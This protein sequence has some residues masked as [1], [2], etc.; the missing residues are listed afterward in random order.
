MHILLVEDNPGDARMLRE[1]VAEEG[2]TLDTVTHADRLE[3]GL[4]HVAEPGID[5]V[6][7]DLSLP[8]STGLETLVRMHAAAKEVPIVVLTGVEDEALGV[9]LVQTGAQDYLVKGQVTA[10][11]LRRALRYAMERKARM[12]ELRVKQEQLQALAT[13]LSLAEQRER[14]RIAVELHDYLGQLL[15]LGRLKLGQVRQGVQDIEAMEHLKAADEFMSQALAYTRTLVAELSPPMLQEFGLPIALKWLAEQMQRYELRVEV[16]IELEPLLLSEAQAVLLFQSA[17]EL[18]INVVKH[19]R[20]SHASVFLATNSHGEVCL[21]VT[22]AGCGFDPAATS[23]GAQQPVKFGLLSIRERMEALGGRFELQSAP[24][25]GTRATLILSAV[26]VGGTP[27]VAHAAP[28]ATQLTPV[29]Q[30]AHAGPV[31]VLLV[32]DHT[33][34]RQGVR[35]LLD[36]EPCLQV[37]G[38]AGDGQEAVELARSLKPDVVL[39]DINMPKMDGIEATRRIKQEQ[40]D[41]IVI[42]LSVHNS[43]TM[44][45]AIQAAGAAAFVS[46]DAAAE[47]LAET[48]RNAMAHAYSSR[49]HSGGNR[50]GPSQ[51]ACCEGRQQADLGR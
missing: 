7:L 20:T 34:V 12:V 30:P 16:R 15:A 35:T 39:M 22:D 13:A 44:G 50:D 47:Q 29:S 6:L 27:G 40:P 11:L 36:A 41:T 17:R 42:G 14:H 5:V 2:C 45:E 49:A 24:G 8:D 9:R 23:H 21:T 18:L 10:P 48:I 46:K 1:Y 26:S 28:T 43:G 31:R 37:V 38:E 51:A 33:L 32:D 3:V 19:A 4:R 25:H